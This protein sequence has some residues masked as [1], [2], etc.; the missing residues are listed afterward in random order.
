MEAKRG[1]VIFGVEPAL[2]PGRAQPRLLQDGGP[3]A[4]A[5]FCHLSFQRL[6]KLS[7]VCVQNFDRGHFLCFPFSVDFLL[8]CWF[9]CWFGV[10]FIK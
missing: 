3:Q 6:L 4:G 9:F 10:F 5:F 8:R 1:G 7:A 2:A